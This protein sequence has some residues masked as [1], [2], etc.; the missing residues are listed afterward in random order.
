MLYKIY[1]E[2][3]VCVEIEAESATQAVEIWEN[4]DLTPFEGDTLLTA[5]EYGDETILF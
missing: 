1:A 3:P 2:K 5:I 4:T